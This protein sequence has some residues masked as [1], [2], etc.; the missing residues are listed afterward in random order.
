MDKTG[1]LSAK[2][3]VFTATPEQA[4][5]LSNLM[6]LY[7]YD[8]SEILDNIRLGSDGRFGYPRL[9]LYWTDTD[10]FSFLV[11]VDDD[12]AGFALIKRGSEISG[13]AETWDMTEFFI[14][15]R[16][17]RNGTGTAVAHDIWKRHLGH[18][19]VRVAEQNRAAYAFW[20]RAVSEFM[21]YPAE[22]Q[23]IQASGKNWQVFS[24]V[25]EPQ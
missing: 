3:E 23:W 18:W 8:F 13:D 12:L 25:S 15:R 6:E 19:E 22:S 14:M 5:I 11:K 24:F 21:G 16:Y 9:P 7:I 17:R 2:I 10:R 20:K 1:S 4:P